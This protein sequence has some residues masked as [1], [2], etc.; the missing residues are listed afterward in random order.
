MVGT[1]GSGFESDVPEL[2]QCGW[3]VVELDIH[4]WPL[5][6]RYGNLPGRLQTVGRAER[7]AALMAIRAAKRVGRIVVDLK[8]LEVEATHGTSSK[9]QRQRRTP[10]CGGRFLLSRA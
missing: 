7:Y 1:D 3:S 2:M 5:R 4:G 8:S 10:L 9:Q 6:A